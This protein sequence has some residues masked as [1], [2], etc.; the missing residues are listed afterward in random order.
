M[1]TREDYRKSSIIGDTNQGDQ[2]NKGLDLKEIKPLIDDVRSE[3]RE[4]NKEIEKRTETLREKQSESRF[5]NSKKFMES[6]FTMT[7]NA[8]QT[9]MSLESQTQRANNIEANSYMI[10]SMLK[11]DVNKSLTHIQ[12]DNNRRLDNTTR[13]LRSDFNKSLNDV[14]VKLNQKSK[15]I[16]ESLN[17]VDTRLNQKSKE[18]EDSLTVF[19]GEVDNAMSLVRAETDIGLQAIKASTNKVS[20][21][22]T[23]LVDRVQKLEEI[24]EN[25][26]GNLAYTLL[27]EC[28]AG[29]VEADGSSLVSFEKLNTKLQSY[30]TPN[31]GGRFLRVAKR[32]DEVGSLHSDT[33]AK[34]GLA[35][36]SISYFRS[37][38]F[39][40]DNYYYSAIS[41]GHNMVNRG[42]EYGYLYPS[43]T[44]GDVETAPKNVVYKLCVKGK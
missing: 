14:D 43:L 20:E 25:A 38:T 17:E 40:T 5:Q 19:R 12:E 33:T 27:D 18:I 9:K 24:N 41:S 37:Q 16:T 15:E 11:E 28:P 44:E 23:S 21:D 13:M 1:E 35:I 22:L 39:N 4:R 26:I 29:W 8:Q 6:N 3:S 34:N 30:A 2:I 31:L 10:N 36:N 42:E 7:M 32:N